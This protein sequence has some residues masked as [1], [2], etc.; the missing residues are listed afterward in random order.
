MEG[1]LIAMKMISFQQAATHLL[2]NAAQI[3]Q[4]LKIH[5]I[6]DLELA[7]WKEPVDFSHA[8]KI[9]NGLIDP[10]EWK[11]QIVKRTAAGVQLMKSVSVRETFFQFKGLQ[12]ISLLI[13]FNCKWIRE[14]EDLWRNFWCHGKFLH[15]TNNHYFF[16]NNIKIFISEHLLKKW[17]LSTLPKCLKIN[18]VR[19]Q[20]EREWSQQSKTDKFNVKLNLKQL[21]KI[22]PVA[23][24]GTTG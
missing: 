16:K 12:N 2:H 17:S 20:K 1:E 11:R 8:R 13:W 24:K 21:S 5:I 4:Y 6:T 14:Q 23:Q 10:W 22:F 15:F 18:A 7:H 19:L 3:L 9:T